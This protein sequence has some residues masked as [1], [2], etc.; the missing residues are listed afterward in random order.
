MKFP[1]STLI[2]ALVVSLPMAGP[3]FAADQAA[4]Q[5]CRADFKKLCAG[6]K[7][8]GGRGAECLKQ[9]EA[10]LSA[11]CKTA[12]T[13]MARCAEQVRKVCGSEGDAAAKRACVKAHATELGGCKAAAE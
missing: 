4:T 7:P 6:V 3:A 9:H 10:D 1:F 5:A 8:G 13:S 11:D 12:L 2:A